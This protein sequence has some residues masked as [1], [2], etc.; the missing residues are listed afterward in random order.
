VLADA[1]STPQFADYDSSHAALTLARAACKDGAMAISPPPRS[2]HGSPQD[3]SHRK[4]DSPTVQ[5]IRDDVLSDFGAC[6]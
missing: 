5:A 6:V 4:D 3:W 2:S 1:G